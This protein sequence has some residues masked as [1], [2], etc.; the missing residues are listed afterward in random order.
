MKVIYYARSVPGH[1]RIHSGSYADCFYIPDEK[2]ILFQ[3]RHDTSRKMDHPLSEHPEMLAEGTAIASGS[4]PKVDGVRFSEVKEFQYDGAVLRDLIDSARQQKDWE[5]KVSEGFKGLFHEI[6]PEEEKIQAID[7]ATL[8][9]TTKKRLEELVEKHMPNGNF[10]IYFYQTIK[11]Q[12]KAEEIEN[13]QREKYLRRTLEEVRTNKQ[14]IGGSGW[15][16]LMEEAEALG[17]ADVAHG[18]A[19]LAYKK[20]DDYQGRLKAATILQKPAKEIMKIK[21]ERLL[22]IM[23]TNWG[24]ET[25]Y[26]EV[27]AEH[28]GIPNRAVQRAARAAYKLLLTEERAGWGAS[29]LTGRYLQAAQLAK[30]YLKEKEFIAVGRKLVEIN[31]HLDS[32]NQ[33]ECY[34]KKIADAGFPDEIVRPL[35]LTIFEPTVCYCSPSEA[36]EI[37]QRYHLTDEEMRLPVNKAHERALSYGQLEQVLQLRKLYGSLIKEEKVS[38]PDVELLRGMMKRNPLGLPEEMVEAE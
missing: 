38:T 10:K 17:L 22:S 6:E 3:G 7:P 24:D 31:S 11:N 9:E 20:S 15:A 37:Q 19:E 16:D 36:Q 26:F 5:K 21:E 2:V 8:D 35:A 34:G 27:I 18:F 29:Y 4:I 33:W 13:A 30:T 25:D 1:R 12:N 32:S 28:G 23:T 14:S